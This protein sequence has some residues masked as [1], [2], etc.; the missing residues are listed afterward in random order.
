M[1]DGVEAYLQRRKSETEEAT[2]SLLHWH[3]KYTK[4][5]R[6]LINWKRK[7]DWLEKEAAERLKSDPREAAKQLKQISHER[8]ILAERMKKLKT[9]MVVLEKTMRAEVQKRY[10]D[11]DLSELDMKTVRK[12]PQFNEI[13]GRTVCIVAVDP[14]PTGQRGLESHNCAASSFLM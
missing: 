4:E 12:I 1:F 6:F 7:L 5:N 13:E 10:P 11:Y 8:T 3:E 9:T 2:P 14:L